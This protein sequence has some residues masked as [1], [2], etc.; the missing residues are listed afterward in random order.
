MVR[1]E[2]TQQLGP[3]R[4][5]VGRMEQGLDALDALR[6]VSERLEPLASRLGAMVGMR[7]LLGLVPPPR[8]Q[9]QRG[10]PAR[11]GAKAPKAAVSKAPKAAVSKAA[12]SRAVVSKA[13]VSE[14]GRGCAVIGC[15]RPARSKGYCSAHYQKLRLLIK[16]N[17]RPSDWK[18]DAAPQ[19][20]K[21]PVLPRG[22][23]AAKSGRRPAAAAPVAPPKA[24]AWV[25]KKGKSGMVSLN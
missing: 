25:R 4:K 20:V 11:R 19:S 12:V 22:R 9:P 7:G 21:D 6:E 23:A 18:D 17:R 2:L 3:L 14:A 10:R 8:E 16:T 24:K 15:D 13:A 5:A 1:H